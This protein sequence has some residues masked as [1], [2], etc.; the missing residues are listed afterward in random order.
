MDFKKLTRLFIPI[1]VED[2]LSARRS[3]HDRLVEKLQDLEFVTRSVSQTSDELEIKLQILDVDLLHQLLAGEANKFLLASRV[4]H[5][6]SIQNQENNASWQ[7]IE[8]YYSAYYAVHYL[9]RLTGISITNLDSKSVES[10]VRSN[11]SAGVHITVP[12]GLYTLEYEKISK[13]LTLKKNLKKGSGGSHQDAWKLWEDLVEK[14]RV[15]TNSDPVEYASTSVDLS[16]HKIF[17]VKS[18][19]KYNPSDIRGEINYQFKGGSWMFEKNSKTSIGN[20]QRSISNTLPQAII[21]TPSPEALISNNKVIIGLAKA[22]F[23][24]A[25]DSYPRSICRSIANKYSTYV[26]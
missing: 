13:I 15:G 21:K 4:S 8:H 12:T 18:T 11:I 5:E 19:A 24:H 6:R 1:M 26:V 22:I 2:V 3:S 20:I 25:S 16:M 17:L 10:I 9:I 7:A 23:S 14:L